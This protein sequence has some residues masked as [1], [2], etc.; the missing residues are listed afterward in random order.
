MFPYACSALFRYE[1]GTINWWPDLT[2]YTNAIQYRN[3]VQSNLGKGGIVPRFYP[4]RG[5]SKSAQL[6]LCIRQVAAYDWLFGCNL[7]QLRVF[8]GGSTP[9]ISPSL[10]SRTPSNTTSLDPTNVPAKWH[11]N[12]SNGLSRVRV[13]HTTDR[14]HY[15]EMYSCRWNRLR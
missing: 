2:R 7:H 3:K 12:P 4:L 11:L 6:F 14:P 1:L 13:W 10:G 9:K 15:G 5:S 8:A